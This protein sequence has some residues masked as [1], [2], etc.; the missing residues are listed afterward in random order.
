MVRSYKKTKTKGGLRVKSK[1]NTM[2]IRNYCRISRTPKLRIMS[3]SPLL[4]SIKP[5]CILFKEYTYWRDYMSR[6]QDHIDTD[7]T[8]FKNRR[9]LNIKSFKKEKEV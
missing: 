2:T 9:Y 1:I 7:A 8:P 3:Y 6:L 4:N 5:G